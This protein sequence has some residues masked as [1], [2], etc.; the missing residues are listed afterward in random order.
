MS[1]RRLRISAAI[2]TAVVSVTVAGQAAAEIWPEGRNGAQLSAVA[3]DKTHVLAPDDMTRVLPERST[4]VTF[5]DFVDRYVRSHQ[6]QLVQTTR[7]TA[8]QSGEGFDW[9]AA[10]IGASTTA[11]LLLAFGVGIGMARRLRTRSAVA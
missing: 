10:G 4:P 5:P 9:G 8:S 6:T 2:V 7:P 11:A 3:N 1:I